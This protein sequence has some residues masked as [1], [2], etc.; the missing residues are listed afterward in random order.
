MSTHSSAEH[1]TAC[2]RCNHPQVIWLSRMRKYH[3]LQDWFHCEK[4][5][6][7]FTLNR[8]HADGRGVEDLA[9]T[10]GSQPER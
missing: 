8:F 4:C 2:P 9:T 10:T 6:H 3:P 7:I 5:D 1:P